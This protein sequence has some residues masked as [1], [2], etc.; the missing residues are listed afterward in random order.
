MKKKEIRNLA[1]KIVECELIIAN[2][3]DKE[4]INSA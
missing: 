2:S 1:K 3:D 4:A